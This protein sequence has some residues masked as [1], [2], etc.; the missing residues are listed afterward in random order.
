M[1]LS[2]SSWV[3]KFPTSTDVEALNA[4][5]RDN[6][7]RFISALRSA[8]ADVRISATYRPAERAFLMHYAF[9]IA[10][11]KLDPTKV[12]T[13][14]DIDIDWCHRT[15]DGSLDL[16]ASRQAAEDMVQ[17][18]DIAF[19][20][21]LSSNHT[22]RLAI[23]MTIGWSSD[24][25]NVANASGKAVPIKSNPHSGSNRDLIAVGATY[26]VIKL[27]SDPPHWSFDG[28]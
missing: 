20:P 25:I 16:N 5:F 19:R 6:V 17:G 23:D 10:R 4:P 28:H 27:V 1:P 26:K 14:P 15:A 22:L 9:R 21:A 18:Y 3:S 11:E 12:P 8:G 2:G 7:K 13:N 24:S